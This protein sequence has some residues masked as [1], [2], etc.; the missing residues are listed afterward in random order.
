MSIG[1]V[2]TKR[3]NLFLIFE[4]DH[5]KLRVLVYSRL[6]NRRIWPLIVIATMRK[7]E[8]MKV[9]REEAGHR[10]A[11][12]HDVIHSRTQKQNIAAVKTV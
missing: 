9:E 10:D 12:S 6:E 3:Q 2:K 1:E 8:G 11:G 5:S 4:N 7:G